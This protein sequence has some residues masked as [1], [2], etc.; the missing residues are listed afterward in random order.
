MQLRVAFRNC[1]TK[2]AEKKKVLFYTLVLTCRASGCRGLRRAEAGERRRLGGQTGPAV[3]TAVATPL[4]QEALRTAGD[5]RVLVPVGDVELLQRT[6][7]TQLVLRHDTLS[8]PTFLQL[9]LWGLQC[10]QNI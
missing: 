7:H 5:A 3:A 6:L 2:R 9:I 10:E 4:E 8:C 1:F